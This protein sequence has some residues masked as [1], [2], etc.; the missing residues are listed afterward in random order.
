MYR[1]LFYFT[2]IYHAPGNV[3]ELAPG[4]GFVFD[5]IGSALL[6]RI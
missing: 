6:G 1:S 2:T 5:M 3:D 4:S